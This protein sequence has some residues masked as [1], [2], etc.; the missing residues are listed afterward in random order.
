MRDEIKKL[1][2]TL[3]SRWDW[4]KNDNGLGNGRM[5]V[6]YSLMYCGACFEN[7]EMKQAALGLLEDIFAD[8]TSPEFRITD[9]TLLDGLVGI[10][11]AT[12][13]M[14]NSGLLDFDLEYFA[15]M[16]KLVYQQSIHQLS[17]DNFD[18]LYGTMGAL[19]YFL[20]RM[21]DQQISSYVNH[22]GETLCA[23]LRGVGS[24]ENMIN[25][26][27]N[28]RDKRADEEINYTMAHGMTAVWLNLLNLYE[29]TGNE[30]LK[31]VIKNSINSFIEKNNGLSAARVH[32]RFFNALNTVE[33]TASYVGRLGWCSGDLNIL[34]VLYTGA[35]I[36]GETTWTDLANVEA[37]GII[38]RLDYSAS[39]VNDPFLCHGYLGVA[40]YY[41][42]LYSIS[43][44]KIFQPVS[45]KWLKKGL[46]H[47]GQLSNQD[48][49]IPVVKSFLYGNTGAVLPLVSAYEPK[50]AHW[51][52]IILL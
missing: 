34:Q 37:T 26:S 43:G 46:E 40:H 33:K 23:R 32:Q 27:Y 47:F 48:S 45:E 3:I 16:D 1:T 39:L 36:L 28:Q 5:G 51:S 11:A 2:N 29:A 35:N 17:M 38:S 18:F 50:L 44:N 14:V 15:E 20:M 21:P 13:Q 19:N 22:I 6:A 7:G 52:K 8:I 24:D 12:S 25:R 31:T 4:D 41:Q 49:E 42:H 30:E 9:I 10:L